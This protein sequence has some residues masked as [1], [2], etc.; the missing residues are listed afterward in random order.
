M[1]QLCEAISTTA[2]RVQVEQQVC[3]TL[4]CHHKTAAKI[5]LTWENNKTPERRGSTTAARLCRL[6]VTADHST[7]SGF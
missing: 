7:N 4:G 2:M 5:L 6:L 3:Q 1:Q